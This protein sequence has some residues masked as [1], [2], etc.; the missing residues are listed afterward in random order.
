MRRILILLSILLII[1]LEQ[2]ALAQQSSQ[3]DTASTSIQKY[4][5][6]PGDLLDVRVFAHPELTTEVIVS[7]NGTIRLPQ[8]AE[9]IQAA[10]RTEAELR[11][12][13]AERYK[14]QG[15]YQ[16]Y[17]RVKE[18][19]APPVIIKGA[20]RVQSSLQ[21]RRRIRLMEA[22]AVTGGVTEQASGEIRITRSKA[23]SCEQAARASEEVVYIKD[24]TR[25]DESANPFIEPGDIIT[26]VEAA[27]V[28]V[29]GGVQRPTVIK[30]EKPLTI[31]QAIEAAGGLLP[32]VK[33][34][35][36]KV[37]RQI[38]EGSAAKIISIDLK[39]VSKDSSQDILLQADDV[40]YVP[41][42]G[43]VINPQYFCR[44]NKSEPAPVAPPRPIY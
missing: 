2:A 10:C 44:P 8:L 26:V 15:N 34:E 43:P 17:I 13:V 33:A 18:S 14:A 25:R 38:N 9:E 6:W 42:E 39:R 24:L 29:A 41:M 31:T 35:G 4:R 28:F 40:V 36:V 1:T 20:V 5:I 16:V 22:L 37:C 12:D 27:R 30:M 23:F 11:R 3:G 7:A 21:P 19:K 32:R